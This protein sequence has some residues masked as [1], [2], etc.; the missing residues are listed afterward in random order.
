VLLSSQDYLETSEFTEFAQ[1]YLGVARYT[2]GLTVTGVMGAM[3]DPIGEGLP[4]TDLYYPFQNRSEAL[5]PTSVARPAF[6]GQHG[7]PVALTLERQ[8]WKT[9]FFAFPLE[10]L[11]G[12]ELAEVMSRAIGWLSPLGDSQLAV[13]RTAA[14]EGEQLVYTLSIRNTGPAPLSDVFVSNAVPLSTTYV[15]GS[16]EGP[17]EYS[18]TLDR[19]T[20]HGSLDTGQTVT[21][22]YGLQLDN[23]MPPAVILRNV[24]YLSDESGLALGRTA[25]SRVNAPDL[26]GS[27]LVVNRE[28]STPGRVLT[29]TFVLQ[30]A[31]PVPAQ[32]R[33]VD[34]IPLHTVYRPGSA[35]AST[36]LITNPAEALEWNGLISP[37]DTVSI[38]F[39]VVPD[40]SSAASFVLNRAVLDDG[41]N[42]QYPMETYTWVNAQAFLP[43]I[44]KQ[45]ETRE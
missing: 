10:T 31:G 5:R 34:P 21:I 27:T 32:A 41:W 11:P 28:I 36:G 33:L 19:F 30:N 45:E 35:W 42:A 29:Y 17:G 3:G 14:S 20:W 7:Q 44:L 23:P 26:S 24:A 43:I 9:A 40:V 1:D 4:L 6:W 12:N 15:A 25:I 39:S 22:R 13:D 16:L 37:G 38:H 2:E 18:A 8:P